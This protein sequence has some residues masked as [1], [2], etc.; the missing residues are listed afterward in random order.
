MTTKSGKS[1]PTLGVILSIIVLAVIV[2]IYPQIK[3]PPFRAFGGVVWFKNGIHHISDAEVADRITKLNAPHEAQLLEKIK[4]GTPACDALD[5][6]FCQ[7]GEGG[8]FYKTLTTAAVPYKPGT[9][10]KKEITSY[11]TLCNDGTFSPSCAVG[12]GAC[13]WHDGV[14]SYNVP[15][16]RVIPGIPEVQPK[17]ASYSYSGA[18]YRESPLYQAPETPALAT[19]VGY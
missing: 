6:G 2:T 13:S 5:K 11:C 14:T 15:Q 7:K 12:R 8:Y 4:S 1:S 17:P 19:I 18:S 3:N 10:D 16:Y 9:P